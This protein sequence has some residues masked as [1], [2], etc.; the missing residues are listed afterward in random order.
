MTDQKPGWGVGMILLTLALTILFPPYGIVA[1]IID[2]SW[3]GP[4]RTQGV[5]F[6]AFGLV[7]AAGWC[8][9]F[10]M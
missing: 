8:L 9:H 7:A 4:R 5:A 3:D 1:G 6:F 2:M 10:S